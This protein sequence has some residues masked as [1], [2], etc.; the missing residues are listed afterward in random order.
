MSFFVDENS[1]G[2]D[3]TAF[4]VRPL[5]I[6]DVSKKF[7]VERPIDPDSKSS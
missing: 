7:V 3:L 6:I 2:C 4:N 5:K 1:I